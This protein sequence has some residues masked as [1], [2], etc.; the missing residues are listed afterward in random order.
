MKSRSMAENLAKDV[1][2]AHKLTIHDRSDKSL[3]LSKSNAI[4]IKN[5]LER[6]IKEVKHE[7]FVMFL[8]KKQE[9]ILQNKSS[10]HIEE[11]VINE[12]IE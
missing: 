12:T 6:V 5:K 9:G 2:K 7:D 4:K 10:N 8:K 11:E 3:S 1:A